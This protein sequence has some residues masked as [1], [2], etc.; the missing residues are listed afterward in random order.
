MYY[1]YAIKITHGTTEAAPLTQELHVTQG[2]IHRVEVSFPYGCAGLAH[3]QI[4]HREQT[5]LPTNP[6]GSFAADGY[7]IPIDEYFA[8]TVEPYTLKA[9]LWNLDDTY[10]HTIT[11]RVGILAQ[12]VISPF[13]G[14]GNMLRKFLKLVGLGS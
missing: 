12:D 10:D 2:I 13:F 6:E 1:D 5:F 3:C 11:I 7:V 14:L 4:R 9:V 8:L